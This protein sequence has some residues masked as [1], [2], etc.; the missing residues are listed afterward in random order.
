MGEPRFTSLFYFSH[1]TTQ[2]GDT[3]QSNQ[4]NP[5]APSRQLPILRLTDPLM[6]DTL[7]M[8]TFFIFINKVDLNS[9]G[10]IS[11][12]ENNTFLEV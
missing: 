7:I 5:I 4:H 11:L 1:L 6:L 8:A 10:N 9:L 3:P 2:H 12:L